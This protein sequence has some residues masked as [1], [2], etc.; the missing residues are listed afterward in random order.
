MKNNVN[1]KMTVSKITTIK[2]GSVLSGQIEAGKIEVGD[3][4]IFEIQNEKN[5]LEVIGISDNDKKKRVNK[6][7]K[8]QDV[9]L[10]VKEKQCEK[11]G[12]QEGMIIYI[13]QETSE[14]EF[15]SE[16]FGDMDQ[17]ENVIEKSVELQEKSIPQN[18]NAIR[19]VIVYSDKL[20]SISVDGTYMEYISAIQNIPI[21]NWFDIRADRSGWKGLI[22][23]IRE[24]IDDN[25]VDL[26]FEFNGPQESKYI[27]EKCIFELGYGCNADGMSKDAIAKSNFA[28]AEKAEHRGLYQRAFDYY[29]KAA[30]HGELKE[31]QYKIGEYYYNFCK[32]EGEIDFDL[33]I[34]EA[35]SNAINYYEM[36]ANQGYVDA[37]IRLSEI[38]D[39]G[40]YVE[41][42]GEESFKWTIMAAKQG[43]AEGEYLAAIS[44]QCGFGIEENYEE[45]V[46]WY[47]K[48]AEQGH[49][50]A[51]QELGRAYRMGDLHLYEDDKMAFYYYMEAAKRGDGFS[52]EKIGNF[53]IEGEG[54]EKSEKKAEKWYRKAFNSYMAEAAKGDSYSQEQ[55]AEFYMEGRGVEKNKQEAEKWYK[56]ALDEHVEGALKGDGKEQIEVATFY[57]EG[58]GIEKDERESIRWYEK[59]VQ[60]NDSELDWLL[61]IYC[62]SLGEYYKV[63][64]RN[65]QEAVKWFKKAVEWGNI[66]AESG[67][68]YYG[69]K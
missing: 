60:Q 48:A 64:K 16:L 21:P 51:C 57:I 25:N 19:V 69:F 15:F 42:N 7:E 13:P 12:L 45:A 65:K 38:F 31:A 5:K 67:L 58:K 53:Y 28:E 20:E 27:F 44:Y 11:I 55:I 68:K 56:R 62:N 63:E 17:T 18:E 43:Y 22:A 26:N 35:I 2:V 3:E 10:L 1:F 66:S 30:E 14:E 52:Q 29:L 61:G 37:Q 59:A 8:N 41:E 40:E 47:K 39:E 34:E 23:E 4:I 50:E 6:A 24:M 46:K 49:I 54:V 9:G 32:G 33:T 36:A